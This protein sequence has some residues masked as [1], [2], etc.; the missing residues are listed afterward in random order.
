MTTETSITAAALRTLHR[1]HRQLADLRER[2]GRGPR[3]ARAHEANLKQAEDHLAKVREEAHRCRMSADRKQCDLKA[4]EAA[5]EKRRRQLNEAKD[6][7]E[8]Q[9]LREDIAAAVAAKDVLE[10][11][12]LEALEKLDAYDN[13]IAEAEAAAAKTRQDGERIRHEVLE[14]EPLLRGDIQRLEAELGQCE[15]ALPAEFRE[16]YH[17]V[18][19]ARGEDALA[20]VLGE[21]CG[22]CNQHIPLNLVNALLLARPVFCKAC[23]RL[24]YMPEESKAQP[25][26]AGE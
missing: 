20:P 1:L 21:F 23:G 10:I 3:L 25:A 24:L 6:N 26:E 7:R 18:I 8:Y 14:Q 22:G 4:S 13:R 16:L 12:I 9:V 2:L 17:R 19:R 15:A 11:E 5:I